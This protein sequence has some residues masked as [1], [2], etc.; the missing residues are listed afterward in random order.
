ME[1]A[2][3]AVAGSVAGGDVITDFTAGAGLEGDVI[4]VLDSVFAWAKGSTDGTVVL[5]TGA[6]L[7]ATDTAMQTQSFIL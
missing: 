1:L 3:I 2:A 7:V 4:R 6:D 5:A